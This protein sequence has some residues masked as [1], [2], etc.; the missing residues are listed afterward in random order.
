MISFD[1]TEHLHIENSSDFHYYKEDNST[2]QNWI[3]IILKLNNEVIGIAKIGTSIRDEHLGTNFKSLWYLEISKKYQGKGYSKL[4][5]DF[6]FKYLKTNNI[7]FTTSYYS[8]IGKER[9][10]KQMNYYAQ[11]YKVHFFDRDGKY[12]FEYIEKNYHLN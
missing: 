4:L 3:W 12:E 9:I 2:F 1:I 6:M 5:I 10:Y 11:K 7:T 8:E